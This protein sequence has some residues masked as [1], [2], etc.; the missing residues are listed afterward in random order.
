[1]T[2]INAIIPNPA[3]RSMV[4]KDVLVSKVFW[5]VPVRRP[6]DIPSTITKNGKVLSHSGIVLCSECGYVLIEYMCTG[7]VYVQICNTFLPRKKHFNY[8]KFLFTTDITEPQIPNQPITVYDVAVSM[9][10]LMKGKEYNTFTHNCHMARYWTLRKYG[11][12][13]ENPYTNQTNILFQGF[14]DYF[15]N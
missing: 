2:R 14:K 13:S 9:I 12:E 7:Q 6:L 15:S 11:M 3:L 4:G 10:E 8:R 1:M 5:A